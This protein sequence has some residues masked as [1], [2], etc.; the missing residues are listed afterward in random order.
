MN[1]N[2][3][4]DI[5]AEICAEEISELNK[6]PPFKPSLRH[7]YAMARIFSSFEKK[8]RKT[9]GKQP[10][11]SS[12]YRR[13]S[14]LSTRLVILIAVIVCAALLTG[15]ILVYIS[16][17]FHGTV[18]EDNTQLFPINMENGLETIEYEYYLPVLP[19]G[20]EIIN[21]DIAPYDVYTLYMN[22]LSGQTI[23]FSQWTKKKY[24]RHFNTED[25]NFEKIEIN[26][27]EGIFIYFTEI[28]GVRS[29]V[30]W[31]NDDFILELV[32]NMPKNELV[33]LAKSAKVLESLL[34]GV[35]FG[36]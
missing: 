15:A 13:P 21:H 19:E 17:S 6:F 28:E 3:L 36:H 24:S 26:G 5:L 7:R 22:E 8:S 4:R 31:D 11:A 32:G 18:H 9:S 25:Y 10:W 27:H 33:D 23:T 1:E 2:I 30:I 34:L 16:K 29:I 14:R 12:E 35:P 20:F